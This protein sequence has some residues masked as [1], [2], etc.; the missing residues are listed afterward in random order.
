MS[1][2][3][4][5]PGVQIKRMENGAQCPPAATTKTRRLLRFC[6][7]P[8]SPLLWSWSGLEECRSGVFVASQTT[9]ILSGTSTA[10]G[11]ISPK[12]CAN[13]AAFLFFS[14]ASCGL[15]GS[16]IG[17]CLLGQDGATMLESCPDRPSSSEPL[18]PPPL[19]S[20]CSLLTPACLKLV[21]RGGALPARIQQMASFSRLRD[22]IESGPH[23]Q[24][25]AFLLFS[26]C[27]TAH[28]PLLLCL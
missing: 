28:F 5:R 2:Q 10:F 18:S 6:S 11:G 25:A 19:L 9:E 24:L 23:S 14:L 26:F 3:A 12:R 17:A 1:R 20:S 27:P 22:D 16:H 4:T 8:S 15:F 7:E 13:L 21:R